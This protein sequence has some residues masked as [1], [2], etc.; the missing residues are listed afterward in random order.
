MFRKEL[1]KILLVLIAV[2]LLMALNGFGVKRWIFLTM[3]NKN[4]TSANGEELQFVQVKKE[5]KGS[6]RVQQYEHAL[7]ALKENK[8]PE[9][10]EYTT[11]FCR[12]YKINYITRDVNQVIVDFSSKNLKGSILQERL[13]IGQIVHTLT[14]SFDEVESVVFTVDGE[15]AETLMGNVNIQSAFTS[16]DIY[17]I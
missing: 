3:I 13:L 1:L 16:A 7:Q 2:S 14:Q 17:F 11:A 15:A 12:D 5:I 8:I 4:R 9:N 6:S 10:A